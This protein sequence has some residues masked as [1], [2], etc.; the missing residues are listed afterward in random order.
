MKKIAWLLPL[1]V[2]MVLAQWIVPGSMIVG[3]QQV[4]KKGTA[5]K[6]RCR[7][8]DPNDPFRGKYIVL[9]FD[10]ER[11]EADT[12]LKYMD[13]EQVYAMLG[14]DAEGFARFTEAKRE[15]PANN[16]LYLKLNILYTTYTDSTMM[17][18]FDLPFKKFYMEESKAPAAENLYFEHVSDT[19]GNTYGLVYVHNGAARIK[20]VFIR[21]TSVYELL[22]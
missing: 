10:A 8:I 12:N 11:L 22:R 9:D 2:V 3:S 14:T 4:F 15:L 5:M 17:L 21:D 16:P 13:G 18:H 19:I 6:F 7:P 1:F 20:D